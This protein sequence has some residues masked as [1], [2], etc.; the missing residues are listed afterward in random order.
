MQRSAAVITSEKLK[1]F[2]C[3]GIFKELLDILLLLLISLSKLGIF[4]QVNCA[5]ANALLVASPLLPFPRLPSSLSV[6]V[7]S[8]SSSSSTSP[9][10]TFFYFLAYVLKK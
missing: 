2:L 8:S 7:S 9:G 6:V 4:E 10:S 5:D 3:E 1:T